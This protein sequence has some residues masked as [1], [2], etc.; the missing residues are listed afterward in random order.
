MNEERDKKICQSVLDGATMTEAGEQ[1]GITRERVRQIVLRDVHV[2]GRALQKRRKEAKRK[3]QIETDFRNTVTATIENDWTCDICGGWNLRRGYSYI[4]GIRDY[5]PYE[6]CSKECSYLYGKLRFR[7]DRDTYNKNQARSVLANS[8]NEYARSHAENV[9]A[10]TNV[11]HSERFY[12]QA[13]S[14]NS[15]AIERIIE[16]RKTLGTE[17][18][19]GDSFPTKVIKIS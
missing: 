9:L 11:E 8:E 10:G 14:L 17:H 18:L 6:R 7:L 19:F 13:G 3:K 2:S 12:T 1:F 15:K 4:R 5:L 16:L